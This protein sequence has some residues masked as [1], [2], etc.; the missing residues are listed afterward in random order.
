M[1]L[2]NYNE[3]YLRNMLPCSQHSISE[4][5][6]KRTADLSSYG[7]LL[8]NCPSRAEYLNLAGS[9]RTKYV[10]ELPFHSAYVFDFYSRPLKNVGGVLFAYV[11]AKTDNHFPSCWKEAREL[12]V[13]Y[14]RRKIEIVLR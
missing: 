3:V 5:K 1:C 4:I 7:K 13:T 14:Y 8:N 10:A 6:F 12:G 2:E 11:R 9:I